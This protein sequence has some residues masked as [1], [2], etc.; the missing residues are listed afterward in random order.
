[1]GLVLRTLEPVE[2]L[3]VVAHLPGC[4]D[5]QAAVRDTEGV[6]AALGTSVEQVEPPAR[7]RD[8]ILDA[9]ARTP[10]IGPAPADGRDVGPGSVG[11][12][13]AGPG[14]AVPR[15]ALR[16]AVPVGGPGARAGSPAGPAPSRPGGPSR[17]PASGSHRAP[18]RRARTLVAAALALIVAAGIGGLVARTVQLQN[19][20]DAQIAQTQ[21]I[22]DMVAQFDRPGVSHAWLAAAPGEAPVA[23]VM[24]DGDARVVASVGLAANSTADDTYVLWG[25]GDGAPVPL[26]TFDVG[27]AQTGPHTIG[28]GPEAPSYGAYAISLERGRV[29]PASPTKVVA[30]G[31]VEI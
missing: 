30:T 8:S 11:P 23:A 10:Q 29:A 16:D 17:P 6:L 28:S 21:T 24:V 12:S 31:Q 9:A 7:L 2:E 13:G 25:M 15:E 19:Q 22:V 3:E 4:A 20:R 1:M 27:S 14:G 5:C 26:G 18:R